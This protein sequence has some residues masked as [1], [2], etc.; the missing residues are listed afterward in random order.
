MGKN[1]QFAQGKDTQNQK[2]HIIL[3]VSSQIIAKKTKD[4]TVTTL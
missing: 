4:K 3:E 1:K 2:K